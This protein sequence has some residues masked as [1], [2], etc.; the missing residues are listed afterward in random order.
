M[1][2]IGSSESIINVT[3]DLFVKDLP[4]FLFRSKTAFVLVKAYVLPV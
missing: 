4:Q 3:S 2:S 1:M